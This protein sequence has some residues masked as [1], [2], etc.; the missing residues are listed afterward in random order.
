M[1]SHAEDQVELVSRAVVNRETRALFLQDPHGYARQRNV[2][3]DDEFVDRVVEGILNVEKDAIDVHARNP[4]LVDKVGS[5][6]ERYAQGRFKDLVDVVGGG[7]TERGP[8]IGDGNPHMNAAAV[9]AAAAVVGAAAAVVS[10]AT[11]VYESTKFTGRDIAFD[12]IRPERGIAVGRSMGAV[13]ADI[14]RGIRIDPG[15]A[16]RSIGRFR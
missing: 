12:V 13:N 16:G 5:V 4:F 11:A 3:L 10:A 6:Q 9:A 14:M 7:V 15:R 2:E 8:V 1:S